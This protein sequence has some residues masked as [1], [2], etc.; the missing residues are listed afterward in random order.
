MQQWRRRTPDRQAGDRLG[1]T[2]RE[3]AFQ[4]NTWPT[5]Q[6]RW[7][8]ARRFTRPALRRQHQQVPFILFEDPLVTWAV[9]LPLSQNHSRRQLSTTHPGFS[10]RWSSIALVG[11]VHLKRPP[12]GHPGTRTGWNLVT[13]PRHRPDFG[14]IDQ[15]VPCARTMA[16]LVDVLI[17][18]QGLRQ[19]ITPPTPWPGRAPPPGWP[20][21]PPPFDPSPYT[22]SPPVGDDHDSPWTLCAGLFA[23]GWPR[24]PERLIE[25]VMGQSS[26]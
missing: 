11:S 26:T 15:T 23:D 13:L 19:R 18:W 6:C 20:P 24:W 1:S 10:T 12:T 16:H 8:S 21:P 2:E 3:G 14:V 17:S 7:D 25:R 22:P 9:H 4:L 5:S